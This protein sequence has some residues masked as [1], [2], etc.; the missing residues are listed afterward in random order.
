[1]CIFFPWQDEVIQK[2]LECLEEEAESLSDTYAAAQLAYA[3]VLAGHPDTEEVM[4]FLESQAVTDGNLAI[5]CS[6]D[7]YDS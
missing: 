1:M 7:L 6:T 5:V 3:Y 4:D 2:A